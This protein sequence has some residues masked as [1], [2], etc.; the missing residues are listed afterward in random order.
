M[1]ALPAPEP[2]EEV[3]AATVT[4]HGRPVVVAVPRRAPSRP[5]VASA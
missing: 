5:A 1:A 4:V 3:V 2:D